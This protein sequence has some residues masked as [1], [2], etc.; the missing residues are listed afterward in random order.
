M[1]LLFLLWLK[2]MT[3]QRF[4][5]KFVRIVIYFIVFC[6][7][8]I[9]MYLLFFHS[10]IWN[11]LK[12]TIFCEIVWLFWQIFRVFADSLEMTF[13]MTNSMEKLTGFHAL[14]STI[15]WLKRPHACM[16]NSVNFN[17]FFRL[18]NQISSLQKKRNLKEPQKL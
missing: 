4:K 14:E 10:L 5:K 12:F 16:K 2:T 13:W 18:N 8:T 17:S 15:K 3:I 7:I 9:S 6:D 11:L 1:L